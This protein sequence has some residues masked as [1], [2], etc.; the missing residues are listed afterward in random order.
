M[1]K[2]LIIKALQPSGYYGYPN[3]F[4]SCAWTFPGVSLM[5]EGQWVKTMG[6]VQMINHLLGAN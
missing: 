5:G 1:G 6:N 4:Q 3:S 2:P